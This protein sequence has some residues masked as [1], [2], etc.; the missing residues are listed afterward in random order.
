MK[1]LFFITPEAT[2]Y[3]RLSPRTLQK[4][5]VDGRGPIFLKFG[6]KTLYEKA[7]LDSWAQASRRRST[8]DRGDGH[9]DSKHVHSGVHEG[10]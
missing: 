6:R 3:Q 4:I 7:D 5:R 8:S 2:E 10:Q 9:K 1:P